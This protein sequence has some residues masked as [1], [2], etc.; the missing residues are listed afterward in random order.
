MSATPLLIAGL[1][2]FAYFP[3]AV[4]I[5]RNVARSYVFFARGVAH[6]GAEGRHFIANCAVSHAPTGAPFPVFLSPRR[7]G[8]PSLF[9]E[10]RNFD[11]ADIG[12]QLRLD[13]RLHHPP[14]V[15]RD[16]PY[17][18]SLFLKGGEFVRDLRKRFVEDGNAVFDAELDLRVLRKRLLP[19]L[20]EEARPLLPSLSR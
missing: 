19:R 11:R 8:L 12:L 20:T 10:Q 2:V 9:A 3:Y 6:D 13:V 1:R 5:D 16:L 18:G 17:L 7:V 15:E 14:T 4:E